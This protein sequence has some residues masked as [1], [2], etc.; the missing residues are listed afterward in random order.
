MDI[1]DGQ[2]ISADDPEQLRKHLGMTPEQFKKFILPIDYSQ[3]THQQA[4]T[5]QVSNKDHGSQ[6]GKLRTKAVRKIGR[7]NP[8]PCK[9]GKKFKKC[10]LGMKRRKLL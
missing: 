1:R 8:C 9:S 3:M 6:L 4:T 7:N 10:C 5:E 2:I